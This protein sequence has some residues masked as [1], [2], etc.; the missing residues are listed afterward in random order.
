MALA[1]PLRQL[2]RECAYGLL[3]G[4]VFGVLLLAF[5]IGDLGTLTRHSPLAVALVIATAALAFESV[6]FCTCI[7]GWRQGK[8]GARESLEEDL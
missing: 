2:A 5:N 4:G 1:S 3:A 6:V 7:G 8:Q